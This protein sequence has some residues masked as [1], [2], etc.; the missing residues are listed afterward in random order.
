[1]GKKILIK[2]LLL[3]AVWDAFQIYPYNRKKLFIN[4]INCITSRVVFI[5]SKTVYYVIAQLQQ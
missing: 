5:S 2:S 1:M 4:K 3:F